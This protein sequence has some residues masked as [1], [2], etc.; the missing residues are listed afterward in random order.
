MT[1]E[2]RTTFEWPIYADATLAG[3]SVLVPLPF[4]DDVSEGFFR[5]RIP[6]SIARSRG[7]TLPEGVAAVLSEGDGW[8]PGFL[9]LPVKLTLGVLKRVSRKLLY[10]LTIKDA[11]EKLSHYWLRAFLI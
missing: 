11:S 7:V 9:R 4:M 5:R 3:L 6:R 2:P 1:A 10:F 8:W